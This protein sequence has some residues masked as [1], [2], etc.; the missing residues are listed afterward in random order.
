MSSA[1]DSKKGKKEK[2]PKPSK[3]SKGKKGEDSPAASTE[4]PPTPKGPPPPPPTELSAPQTPKHSAQPVVAGDLDHD[5]PLLIKHN[6][7]IHFKLSHTN[8]IDDK[9]FHD[10]IFRFNT[11]IPEKGKSSSSS[12]ILQLHAHSAVINLRCE[13]MLTEPEFCCKGKTK[14][15]TKRIKAYVVNNAKLTAITPEIML[16]ILEFIYT[17]DV[18]LRGLNIN[19]VLDILLT[20]EQYGLA[21]LSWICERQ[22]R[23]FLAVDV[24]CNMLTAA[25]DRKLDKVKIFCQEFAI[26]HFQQVVTD[27]SGASVLG[28]NLYQE[29][30]SLHTSGQ[31]INC[32]L[33]PEPQSDIISVYK[34]IYDQLQLPGADGFLQ[35]GEEIQRCHKA[36]LAGHAPKLSALFKTAGVPSKD[37]KNPEPHYILDEKLVNPN[38]VR[39]LLQFIYYGECNLAPLTATELLTL[40]TGKYE[41]T[42]LQNL[43]LHIVSNNVGVDTVLPILAVCYLQHLS[44]LE[45]VET[46]KRN[47]TKFV[48]ENL[49]QINLAPLREM[50][51]QIPVDLLV[52]I[53]DHAKKQPAA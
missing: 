35:V 10:V 33:G 2:P 8:M 17:D 7:E 25:N 49:T 47:A 19:Q 43:L 1:K 50:D 51:P 41:L 5:S 26:A 16:K 53:Q 9:F 34:N 37:K 21:R 18:D 45:K 36:V 31:K 44:G 4:A 46:L 15:M 20:S 39:K 12:G 14:A 42:D 28:L 30:I 13:K 29:L 40:V 23:G 52:A 38:T 24:V 6:D 3:S 22:L 32:P 48:V 27:K 11:P